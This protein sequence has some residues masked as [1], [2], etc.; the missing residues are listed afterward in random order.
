MDK[1]SERTSY[2]N[3][4]AWHISSG[5]VVLLFFFISNTAGQLSGAAALLTLMIFP[6]LV[7][8]GWTLHARHLYRRAEME[9][10][11]LARYTT[12]IKVNKSA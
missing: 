6:A 11:I 4:K 2:L 5:L 12:S 3:I 1:P 9:S 10:K 8:W 7:W